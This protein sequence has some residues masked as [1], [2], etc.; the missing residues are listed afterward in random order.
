MDNIKVNIEK[1]DGNE[2]KIRTG[3]IIE[4]PKPI[5]VKFSG[6]L[7]AP[8]DFLTNRNELLKKNDCRLEVDNNN[9]HLKFY[10]DERS[11]ERDEIEGKLKRSSL[12]GVFG[13]NESKYY[14][15]KQLA[16]FL[17][18]YAFY[19]PDQS[20]LN[21][22]INALMNFE[23]KVTSVFE[24][25]KDLTGNA[26]SMY[27]K[28]VESAIPTPISI[29]LPIFEGYP[30]E[31]IKVEIGAE[32]TSSGVN[33]F[34]ESAEL[35]VLEERLKRTILSSEIKKFEEFGCAILYK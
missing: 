15:D 35:C 4:D 2:I 5:P 10:S 26:K 22:L 13:I 20:A 11:H 6:V 8:G 17:R 25:K 12:I 23:A 1:V 7:S 30:E 3:G 24:N 29:K 27:E 16:K 14:S 34:F 18:Q 31:T 33:F 32:A 19:F 21:K 9:G 28:T